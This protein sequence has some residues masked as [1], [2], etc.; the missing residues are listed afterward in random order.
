MRIVRL[1]LAVGAAVGVTISLP[2]PLA[3]ARAKAKEATPAASKEEPRAKAPADDSAGEEGV[4]KTAPLVPTPGPKTIDL[5]HDMTLALP[6]N[7][8]FF[9]KDQANQLMESMGNPHLDSRMGI[10][11]RD[12][13]SWMVSITYEE[14]GYVKDDEA[15]KMDADEILNAIREGTEEANKFRAEKGFP[16]L[17]VDGWT[18]PPQYDAKAHHLV[19]GIKG[20]SSSGSSVNY[21]T[22]VLG[23]KGYA[24]LNLIDDVDKIEASKPEART[25]LAA[26][27]FNSGARYEDF[28]S[29]KDKVAEY[30][31]AA[32]VAGGA[33]AVA[34]KLVKVGLLAKFGGK[35]I[36][37]LLLGKK[38][39]VLALL[40]FASFFRRLFGK[41]PATPATVVATETQEAATPVSA[42]SAD[43]PVAPTAPVDPEAK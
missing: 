2:T 5:G 23:R 15:A 37:L 8:M 4:H 42:P 17:H 6:E 19:W 21:N 11:V 27:T 32:L 33:G 1:C 24:S 10:V 40:A 12:G 36:A 25:L 28:D 35:L 16:A 20:S 30:G 39:V 13:G 26:T 14:G 29:K 3:Y 31:L 41:K 34:L 18:E 22:R 9:D 7:Y 38:F 43:A